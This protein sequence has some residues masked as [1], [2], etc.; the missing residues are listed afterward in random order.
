MVRMLSRTGISPCGAV[1]VERVLVAW[2]HKK[3]FTVSG[4]TLCITHETELC[5]ILKAM[6]PA[7]QTEMGASLS[8]VSE[9]LPHGCRWGLGQPWLSAL[10]ALGFLGA[11]STERVIQECLKTG[12]QVLMLTFRNAGSVG[13][14]L[15]CGWLPGHLR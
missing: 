4:W 8:S 12:D 5:G 7:L 14:A 2:I 6:H 10:C 3:H 1:C 15:A 11:H 13:G 9:D